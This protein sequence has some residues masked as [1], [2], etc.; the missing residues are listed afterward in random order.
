MEIFPDDRWKLHPDWVYCEY[1]YAGSDDKKFDT[2][3]KNMRH[4]LE[5]LQE[6]RSSFN[7]GNSRV[8]PLP[9]CQGN[10]FYS[11]DCPKCGVEDSI[12]NEVVTANTVESLYLGSSCFGLCTSSTSEKSTLL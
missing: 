6:E 10:G 9:K 5:R 8:R 12:Y 3:E 2:P 1:N 4:F 11:A 7:W